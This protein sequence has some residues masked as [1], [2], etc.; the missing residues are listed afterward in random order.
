MVGLIHKLL[1]DLVETLAS[2][3]AVLE[4]RQRAGIPAEKTFLM[5]EVYDD[6]EWQR[7]F[8]AACDV[9]NVTPQQ[10]EEAFADVFYKDALNRWPVWFQMSKNAREFL[11]RQP[12]IHNGFATGVQNPDQS[13]AI[14]DKFRLE[15]AENELVM[16]Y[17]SPNRLCGLYQA[18]ARRIIDH[19]ADLATVQ[20]VCCLKNEDPECEIHIRWQ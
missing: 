18:L 16:H 20:E 17:R 15:S 9:L 7:L 10:A 2:P 14:N 19:Y 8:A 1:F 6:E 11:E 13:R 3:G 12:R 5:N 4:V